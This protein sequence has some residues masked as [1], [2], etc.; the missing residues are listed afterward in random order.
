MVPKAKKSYATTEKECVAIVWAVHKF[1]HY[2]IGAH[3]LLET[4]H[5]PLEWL[6][7]PKSSKSH[8]QQL[9]RWSLQLHA[10]QF[11]VIHWLGSTNQPADALSRKPVSVVSI[12]STWDKNFL[13]QEQRSGPVLSMLFPNLNPSNG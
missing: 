11:S 6:N 4:D 2:L 12:S 8:S 13:A 3:F 1:R 10:F 5:K 7:T 9:E